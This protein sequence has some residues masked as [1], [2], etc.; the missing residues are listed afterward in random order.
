MKAL[1]V[2]GVAAAVTGCGSRCA[3]VAAR[4]SALLAIPPAAPGPQVEVQVPLAR[5]NAFLADMLSEP[6]VLAL[7]PPEL[8]VGPIHVQGPALVATVRELRLEPAA[9]G[10]VRFA[11]RVELAA[12]SSPP[13][14]T[15]ALELE[16]EPKLERAADGRAEL[17]ARL[18][19]GSRT[20]NQDELADAVARLAPA[21]VPHA[22]AERVAELLVH[23]LVAKL[24]ERAPLRLRLPEVPITSIAIASTAADLTLDITTGLPVRA[25]LA[26]HPPPPDELAVRI[27][28]ST[29]TALANWSIDH[30]RAPQHYTRGL[31]PRADGEFRPYFFY[32]P[33]DARRP[34]KV[35]VFQ[36]RGGCSYVGVGM[37][38]QLA[39]AD[40]QLVVS[41]LDRYIEEVVASAPLEVAVWLD[42]LVRGA[43]DTTKRTIAE[44]DLTIGE[45]SYT[46]RIV[47][48]SAAQDE[49]SF[50]LELEP[51]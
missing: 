51:R 48:A 20:G 33:S 29:A 35:F 19:S 9:P 46:T 45:R 30:G 44:A 39:I 24:G 36:E 1:L 18:D 7:D 14:T 21:K 13:I 26:D 4:Q 34:L 10:H 28:T 5:A 6:L 11:V 41:V 12:G 15:L 22:V 25:P 27:S 50:G 23:H 37:Q 2:L 47:R 3:E 31:K 32:T 42:Q 43:V 17:V 38:L 49:L 8:G 16:I 40:Q